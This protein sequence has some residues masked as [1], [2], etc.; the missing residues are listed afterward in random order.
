M[1]HL[2]SA[3]VKEIV[4]ERAAG[5]GTVSVRIASADRDARSEERMR[6]AFE[7]ESFATWAYDDAYAKRATDP[8]T[9]LAGARSII[10]VAVAYATQPQSR[11]GPLESRVSNYAWSSDYHRRM[12]ALLHE[13][14]AAIDV[15]ARESV[16]RVACDTI[17]IAE[18]A[19]AANAGLGWVGKHT[20]LI[21]PG[22]GSFVFLG[23]ILTTLALETDAPLKKTCG[24]CTR[25]I[26][27]CPTGA[28]RGDYTIDAGRCIADLNQRTDDIP[29]AMRPLL[30]DWL[31]GCDLCQEVCPP[32]MRA[33]T[34][35]SAAFT[36]LAR[37]N[38]F[39]GAL[40]VLR[41]RSGEFKRWFG[42]TAMSWRGAAVLRRNAAV[43]LGNLL[44]RAAVPELLAA[45]REDPH[46]M[47]R[48][49]AAWALGRIGSPLAID[50]LAA[51]CRNESDPSVVQE[52][53]LAAEPFC[54]VDRW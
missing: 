54:A 36:P 31:W 16:T 35:G 30:M 40:K 51:L 11:R 3:E 34:G 2:R 17:P 29:R 5:L 6:A 45:L 10:C 48:R 42:P 27:A 22:S 15:A 18:R 12:R 38:A 28:L 21:V 39:P 49:H 24:S 13:I 26:S 44:D 33:G 8:Q 1:D 46:P 43:V 23:E 52:I 19:F 37:E 20:N 14:A 7:G 25:C 4:S 41:V 53:R 9:V 50:G 32:T 47:V